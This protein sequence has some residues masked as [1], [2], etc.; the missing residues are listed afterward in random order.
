[1]FDETRVVQLTMLALTGCVWLLAVWAMWRKQTGVTRL[2]LG[3]FTLYALGQLGFVLYAW[4]NRVTF[5][6]NLEAMELLK[7]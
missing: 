3:V 1:M 2:L 4:G 7:L 5:P 6:L